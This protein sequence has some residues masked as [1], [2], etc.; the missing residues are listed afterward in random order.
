MPSLYVPKPRKTQVPRDDEALFEAYN[1]E[2]QLM[3]TESLCPKIPL[4]FQ[5]R[6]W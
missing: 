2:E 6:T 5:T 1:L 3:G 4:E